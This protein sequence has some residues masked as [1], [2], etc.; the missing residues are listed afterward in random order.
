MAGPRILV[1][2][3]DPSLLDGVRDMLEFA[4][5]TVTGAINGQE[6]LELLPL[7][8][9]DLI[10]SDVMMPKMDG[11]QFYGAVREHA[12]WLDVPFIFLTAKSDKRDVSRGKELGADDYM[13]KPFDAGDLLL[14]VRNKL[15]R[16]AQ[17]ERAHQWQLDSLRH[18][19]IS[20]LNHEFRT[21]LTYIASYVDLLRTT[22]PELDTG[23]V[24]EYLH[25]I[26]SGAERLKKLIRDFTRLAE[27][28]T[29]EAR[30][31][32]EEHAEV[33]HELPGLLRV[34]IE[35]HRDA[36]KAKHLP[37]ELQLPTEPL[38]ALRMDRELLGDA[39]GRLVENAIKFSPEAAGPV[40]V[41]AEVKP[42]C[43]HLHVI[44]HGPGIPAQ[45]LPFIFDPFG[46]SGRHRQEQ[47]GV[48]NGLTIAREIVLLHG[49]TLTVHSGDGPG[50]TFTV[51]LPA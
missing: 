44:D 8:E 41:R 1:V 4:G 23:E 11:F 15:Q 47:Q 30:R 39:L 16:R 46:Q 22:H 24:H 21:P 42:G 6:A 31:A 18:S 20:V 7:A 35:Q 2:E 33:S 29:G 26:E 13:V 36:A 40:T 51:T 48:G 34:V 50:S 9:P 25:A 10:I 3:D 17:L 28:R 49:G 19:I 27:L 14:A 37:L 5:Y 12:E 32:F 45:D 38:P 43:L